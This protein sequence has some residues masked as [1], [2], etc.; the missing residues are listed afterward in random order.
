M[1][2]TPLEIRQKTFEKVFRGYDKDEV[3]AYLV[4]LSQEWERIL[5]E[6]KEM[7]VRIE[8][9]EKEVSKLREVESSLFKTLKTAEDT[10][11]NL[12]EQAR[13]E[14]ELKIRESH[15][16]SDEI[17]VEARNKAKKLLDQTETKTKK[18]LDE[19]M[20]KVKFIENDYNR[21]YDLREKLISQIRNYASELNERIEKFE[22]RSDELVVKDVVAEAREAYNS[23]LV[24]VES[25]L[26]QGSEEPGRTGST[27]VSKQKESSGNTETAES[28]EQIAKEKTG[29]S[30]KAE[31]KEEKARGISE[32]EEKKEKEQIEDKREDEDRE[33][34]Q[35]EE[36]PAAEEKEKPKSQR[37]TQSFF[38]EIE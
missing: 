36:E 10:G 6:N 24:D 23:A 12:I 4:S 3:N 17:V 13:K 18:I 22:K 19:M 2:I 32:E 16:K 31:L 15:M 25:I 21:I 7:N 27:D 20:D 11:A 33:S 14:T 5:D 1:K 8:T 29:N 26:Q 9:L 38:D 28:K 30:E 34:V 37:S 35:P